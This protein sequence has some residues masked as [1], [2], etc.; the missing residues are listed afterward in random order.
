METL[1]AIII[2]DEKFCIETLEWELEQHC[3]DVEVLATCQ[4]GEQG[5]LAIKTHQ[6]D[7]IF[8]DIEMPY[9]NAFEMLQQIEDIQFDI[10][11]T[12]AY[13]KFAIKAIKV[14]AMDY[15][16]KPIGK[17][18][19]K[20]AVQKVQAKRKKNGSGTNLQILMEQLLLNQQDIRKIALPTID[21]LELIRIDHL[22]Y[23]RADSNYTHFH[24]LSG[25]KIIIS[26]TLKQIEEI[27]SEY[28]YF[29]RIHQTYLVNLHHVERYQKGSGG[30]LVMTDDAILPVAR[31]RKEPLMMRLQTI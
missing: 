22:M 6:P 1:K 17:E 20:A 14:S 4:G 3:S 29:C 13:D 21:G 5:I 8:L 12:T 19:L 2:D 27:L 18:E 24:T 9:M 25:R 31:N 16:L 26:R 7:V 30:S 23:V 15:L 11:F 28:S 10:I